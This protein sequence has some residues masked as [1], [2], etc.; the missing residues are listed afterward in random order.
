STPASIGSLLLPRSTSPLSLR[1]IRLYL[2][3][4]LSVAGS[5]MVGQQTAHE[6][7]RQSRHGAHDAERAA[8]GVLQRSCGSI[9]AKTLVTAADPGCPGA[10]CD[11]RPSACCVLRQRRS[12]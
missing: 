4:G 12:R 6:K 9:S 11:A 10:A 7:P 3:A 2:V 5:L 1:T 8:A